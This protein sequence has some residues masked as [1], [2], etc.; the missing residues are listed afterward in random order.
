MY[1][2]MILSPWNMSADLVEGHGLEKNMLRLEGL[3]DPSGVGAGFS[4]LL[5]TARAPRGRTGDR[6][7]Q[8]PFLFDFSFFFKKNI[9]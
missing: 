4:L 7:A 3:G 8:P 2:E 6:S 5:H 1:E 9:F